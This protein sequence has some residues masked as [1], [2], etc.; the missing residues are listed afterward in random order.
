MATLVL[1]AV[2]SLLGP[3][4]GAVGALIGQSIDAR[5]LKPRGREG[6]RLQ[7]LKVQ[8]S[9]YGSQIPKLFGTM[10]VAGTVIWSTDLIERRSKSGG[11]KG[12]PSTTTYSYSASFAVLLSGRPIRSVGRIWADGNL[13]RGAAGDWKSKTGFRLHTGGEDQLPDPFIV[14]AEAS[15]ATP[16]YRGCAYAVFE[17]MAL[18]PFGNRIPSLTFEV[19]ADP[20][21]VAVAGVLEQVSDGRIRAGSGEIL[22]GFSA[23]GT[24][25]SGL[26]DGLGQALPIE[27]RDDGLALTLADPAEV[28]ALSAAELSEGQS[29]YR[30]A[31]NQAP[32]MLAITHYDPERDFQA[33]IQHARRPNGQRSLQVE[34]PAVLEAGSAR[35]LAEL[36]LAQLAEQGERRTVRCGWAR[37]ACAP[38]TLVSL[39]GS[40]ATWRVVQRNVDRG[41]VKLD[42]VRAFVPFATQAAAGPGRHQPA[43]D[44]VHGPTVLHLLD[45]P[46]LEEAAP[47]RPRLYVA[48]AGPEP[49]WRRATLMSSLDGGASWTVLGGTSPPA[50]IGFSETVLPAGTPN[51][52]DRRAV[53]TVKLLHPEMLLED[54]DDARLLGGANLA[55]IGNELIQ[56]GRAEPLGG[57]RWRLSRLL[58]GRRGTGWAGG[59]HGAGERFV[60]IE[61]EALLPYDL[62]LSAVGGSVRLLASGVGDPTPVETLASS[63]GEA[64]RPPAPVHLEARRRG[65]GGYDVTW[66][67]SSRTGWAW[68]DS[69][70]APLSEDRE[71]YRLTI[72]PTA[73]PERSHELGSPHFHYAAAE[74]LADLTGG[75]VVLSVVQIGTSV[76]SRPAQ[77]QLS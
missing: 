12:R 21:P 68:A 13:L 30:P 11:G 28:V 60:L 20:S 37:L 36:K 4:G 32:A 53:V 14:S 23:G 39:P 2:G 29:Q 51:L 69:T 17:N 35:R 10:R 70:D 76:V 3:I 48:A 75:S 54:A 58:R 55:L 18:G 63:I 77:I 67:R 56:F 5:L 42:L 50:M 72:A 16:A 74:A 43:P 22:A 25:L 38:G 73:G 31:G 71:L 1:T 52:T 65:D 6:P 8:T 59:E 66:I 9:S 62:P 27:L 34:L 47:L 61:P 19:E 46:N 57:S 26:V 44:Q 7:D 64:L 40:Q 45:L 49:G 41:G 15:A 33:G 24:S